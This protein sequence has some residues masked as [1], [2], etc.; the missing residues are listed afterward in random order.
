[1]LFWFVS[2]FLRIHTRACSF[3]IHPL[4]LKAKEICWWERSFLFSQSEKAQR[5]STTNDSSKK[6]WRHFNFGRNRNKFLARY[7]PD[8]FISYPVLVLSLRPVPK[9]SQDLGFKVPKFWHSISSDAELLGEELEEENEETTTH[10][11]PYPFFDEEQAQVNETTQLGNDVYLHCR[12]Q[13]LGEKMVSKCERGKLY[14][15]HRLTWLHVWR[16][17]SHA[18]FYRS[19]GFDVREI[20]CTWLHSASRS[21]VATL[22]THSNS[23]HQTTGSSTFNLP[24]R[25]TRDSSNAK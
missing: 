16:N 12:V 7:Q 4:G 9:Q 19:H 11:E 1:M 15:P 24:T 2:N 14:F 5:A 13:N 17:S 3:I 20:N 22:A 6:A 8:W 18:T 10:H 23:N 21:T 25:G